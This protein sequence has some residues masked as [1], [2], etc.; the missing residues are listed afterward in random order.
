VIVVSLKSGF[1]KVLSDREKQRREKERGE[2]F[3]ATD[4]K[5]SMVIC[6]VILSSS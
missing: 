5:L 4:W 3:V 6:V 2:L 1:V